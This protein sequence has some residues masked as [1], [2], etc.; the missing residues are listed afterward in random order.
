M[1]G[2]R[3][4]T[5]FFSHG[6]KPM[7]FIISK[8]FFFITGNYIHHET[9]IA[10]GC[11]IGH[12]AVVIHAER[13]GKGFE[14]SSNIT[15]GQKIPSRSPFPVIGDYV[16]VGAGVRVFNHVGNE[17]IIGANAVLISP[18]KDG[19]AVAGV[20]AKPVGSSKEYMK[21]YMNFLLGIND[22]K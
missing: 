9:I 1:I 10:P 20:P 15:I 13:I 5:W 6:L 3:L 14:C 19:C 18:V 12:S 22:E 7:A 21:Y 2:C 17:V 8:I 11:K 16:M 4:G